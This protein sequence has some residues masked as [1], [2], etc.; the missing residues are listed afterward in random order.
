MFLSRLPQVAENS[1]IGTQGVQEHVFPE[2]EMTHL[3]RLFRK[4]QYLLGQSTFK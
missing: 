3:D 2:E 4:R 1:N